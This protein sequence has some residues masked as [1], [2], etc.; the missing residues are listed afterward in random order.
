MRLT[1]QVEYR[2]V[3]EGYYSIR[4]MTS[5]V[6]ISPRVVVLSFSEKKVLK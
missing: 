5:L 1:T 4:E 2:V 3:Q 6:E